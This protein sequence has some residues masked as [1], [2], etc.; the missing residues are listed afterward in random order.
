MQRNG[1]RFIDEMSFYGTGM[2]GLEISDN[3]ISVLNANSFYG[4]ERTLRELNLRG[5]RLTAVP[6]AC[7]RTLQKVRHL[8]LGYNLI[9]EIKAG[10]FPENLRLTLRSLSMGH[11]SLNFIDHYAFKNLRSLEQ[12]DL[13]ANNI[14]FIHELAFIQAPI[15]ADGSS[16]EE[17]LALSSL[18]LAENR[19]KKIPFEAIKNIT[20]LK[21]LDLRENLIS[22]TFDLLFKD[23]RL[24][25]QELHLEGNRI[26]HL[27]ESAFE[28]FIRINETYLSYNPINRVDDGAFKHVKIHSIHLDACGLRNVSPNAWVHLEND[29]KMIDLSLNDLQ[30]HTKNSAIL[31]NDSFNNLENLR[32]FI[33]NE[34]AVNYRL[35]PLSLASSQYSL[36]ELSLKSDP[37]S[38]RQS[39]SPI[40]YEMQFSSVR[41]LSLTKLKEAK[42]LTKN[43]LLG[44]GGHN[45]EVVDLSGSGIEEI[46]WDAFNAA[47]S[48]RTLNLS[49][50]YI[51]KVN[52][53]VLKPLSRTLQV[54]D[55]REAFST[56]TL[57]CDL[58]NSL[59]SLSTLNLNDNDL[60]SLSWPSYCFNELRK[61]KLLSLDF[62]A[63]RTLNSDL[64]KSLTSLVYL[65][66]SYN[67]ITT[68]ASETFNEMEN[69]LLLDLSYNHIRRIKSQAFSNLNSIQ[70]IDLEGN[71]IDTIDYEAFVNLPRLKKLNLSFNKL[72]NMHFS[73]FDQVGTLSTFRFDVSHNE[74]NAYT[75]VDRSVELM[76]SSTNSVE[77]CDFSNN[78]ISFINSSYFDSI[79]S[80][81]TQLTLSHNSLPGLTA[82]TVS[83]LKQLQR[84]LL[85]NNRIRS[86]SPF[87]FQSEPNLQIIDM[88]VNAIRELPSNVFEENSNLRILN[89]SRNELRG[90]SDD[91]FLRNVHLEILDVSH[92]R[93]TMLPYHSLKPVSGTLRVFICSNNQI[94][95]IRGDEVKAL[96]ERL[97]VLDVSN[98]QIKQLSPNA[99]N[100]FRQ[101]ISLDLSS[102]PLNEIDDR[103]FD[104]LHKTLQHLNLARL[105]L[106]GVPLLNLHSLT[107]LN[108]SGNCISYIHSVSLRNASQ[109]YELDLSNNLFT[110][111]PNNIWHLLPRLRFLDISGNLIQSLTND[112]FIGLEK[113]EELRI[114]NLSL[115]YLQYG[116]L[117]PIYLLKVLHISLYQNI[118]HFSIG[119]LLL[120]NSGVRE[121]HIDANVSRVHKNVLHFGDSKL[122]KKLCKIRITGKAIKS[123]DDELLAIIE[124]NTLDLSIRETNVSSLLTNI[125]SNLG[126]AR[127]LLLDLRDNSLSTI[128]DVLYASPYFSR[129]N[130]SNR[131][132]QRITCNNRFSFPTREKVRSLD[133]RSVYL[134]NN[135]W[136]CD[137]KLAWIRDW[138]KQIK[139]ETVRL[140]FARSSFANNYNNSLESLEERQN[141]LRS[142]IEDLRVTRCRKSRKSLLDVFRKELRD[143]RRSRNTNKAFSVVAQSISLLC[144]LCSSLLILSFVYL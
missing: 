88:S 10:D 57:H 94:D 24:S 53:D 124:S 119:G 144:L 38:I 59:H 7:L 28:N 97:L 41:R 61:L 103:T 81:L 72:K 44:Y 5:N 120:D 21:V 89:L 54:L 11:N 106:R 58:F 111:V 13:S 108:L 16:G 90:L 104:T 65:F 99:F 140:M 63:L 30:P 134:S 32:T 141:E 137:C 45:L 2:W 39:F 14:H 126:A 129:V 15:T 36:Q 109:L 8:N 100:E 70:T 73:I 43:D 91:V 82:Q 23:K 74:L 26:E 115:H 107:K 80:T 143:C 31:Y 46:A 117:R 142:I 84:L 27:P 34:N 85:D 51:Q 66:L 79:R 49:M 138:F 131:V 112:S 101:L 4:L 127:N 136:L 125:F 92:N 40:R 56:R 96:F 122:A 67:K 69:L 62:N 123:I 95:Y 76:P 60:H 102:N 135:A 48:I 6:S 37:Q 121:L 110:S 18:N 77:Y 33:L 118:K 130:Q 116:A 3:F 105:K 75:E 22:T 132:L 114:K 83:R 78:N 52:S 35:S 93:L 20:Y 19:L 87:A 71:D 42:K 98:N 1:L 128:S 9:N 50:N 55:L 68:I 113:L 86:V 25:L 12:L 29:L 47:P 64:F 17:L 139:H 133:V